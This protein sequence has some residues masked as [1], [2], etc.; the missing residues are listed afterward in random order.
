MTSFLKGVFP[1]G[2]LTWLVSLFIGT[3]GSQGGVLY[4]RYMHVYEQSFYWSWP[5][6][7]AGTALAWFLFILM[8]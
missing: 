4:I 2:L 7:F 5:L 3:A 1:A 6:F 8:D